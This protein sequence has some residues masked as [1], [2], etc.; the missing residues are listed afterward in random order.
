MPKELSL[1][2]SIHQE[3]LLLLW[4]LCLQ[5]CTQRGKEKGVEFS[6][7]PSSYPRRGVWQAGNQRLQKCVPRH[8]GNSG[9]IEGRTWGLQHDRSTGPTPS[10]LPPKPTL[11]ALGISD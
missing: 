2:C 3:K 8:D 1:K 6:S 5:Y 10:F 11:L 7:L 4:L 9:E